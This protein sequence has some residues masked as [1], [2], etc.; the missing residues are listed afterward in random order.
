MRDEQAQGLAVLLSVC[1]VK[2]A[3]AG[4]GRCSDCILAVELIGSGILVVTVPSSSRVVP[5]SLDKNRWYLEKQ[6]EAS[7]LLRTRGSH[8]SVDLPRSPVLC[9]EDSSF[10]RHLTHLEVTYD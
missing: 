4:M 1:S 10:C 9:S 7:T 8:A 5:E 2:A 6:C 3:H